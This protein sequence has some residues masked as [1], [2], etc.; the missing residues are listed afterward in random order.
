MRISPDGE[1]YYKHN[2][3]MVKVDMPEDLIEAFSHVIL[4][5]SGKTPDDVMIDR[6][7]DKIL[8]DSLSVAS[9]W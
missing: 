1:L 5:Y 9:D 4:N 6:Y 7:I 3:I 8:K 2:N